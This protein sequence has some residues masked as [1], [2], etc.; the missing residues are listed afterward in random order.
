MRLKAGVLLMADDVEE[1]RVL[2]LTQSRDGVRHSGIVAADLAE[3]LVEGHVT[4][5][6][7]SG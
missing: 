6:I 1:L 5:R 4:A 2:A 7:F 3:G